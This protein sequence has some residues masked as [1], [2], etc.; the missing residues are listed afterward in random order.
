[1]DKETARQ[2]LRERKAGWDYLA[3]L[4]L[5]ERRK[6]TVAERLRDLDALVEFGKSIG[7]RPVW[8]D[9]PP[10][11]ETWQR[12]RELYARRIGTTSR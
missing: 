4:E 5:E 3:R 2:I 1:M 6:M 10:T 9:L 12:V 7:I 8:T 11:W